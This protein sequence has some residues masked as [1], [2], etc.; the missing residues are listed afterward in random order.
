MLLC[1]GCQKGYHLACLVL[2]LH[3]SSVTT[4]MRMP[5]EIQLFKLDELGRIEMNECRSTNDVVEQNEP[6][7]VGED[8]MLQRVHTSVP[9]KARKENL[10]LFL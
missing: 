7:G 5:S 4:V 10:F 2:S 8:C 1:D 3:A 9:S 6:T